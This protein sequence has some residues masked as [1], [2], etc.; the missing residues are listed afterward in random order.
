MTEHLSLIRTRPRAISSLILLLA[1]AGAAV[2]LRAVLGASRGLS[3]EYFAGDQWDAPRAIQLVTPEIST[4]RI[5]ADWGGPPPPTFRARWFGYLTVPRAG[6]Y[7]FAL[8]SD[9]GSTLQI[10]GQLVVDNGGTHTAAT[11]TGRIRLER[12]PHFVLLEYVQAGGADRLNFL[13]FPPRH[14]GQAE[15]PALPNPLPSKPHRPSTQPYIPGIHD[16]WP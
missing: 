12:G 4:A 5:A 6:D 11:Q 9:D 8:T 1:L 7:T 14:R 3:A 15:F 10:D 2:G 13:S 16:P